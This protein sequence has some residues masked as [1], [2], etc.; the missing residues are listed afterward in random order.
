MLQWK[1]SS[2]AASR[3][4]VLSAF[5]LYAEV[6]ERQRAIQLS[7]FGEGEARLPSPPSGED[8]GSTFP[9]PTAHL[10]QSGLSALSD[11]FRK[12]KEADR[13]D[14][15][16]AFIERAHRGIGHGGKTYRMAEVALRWWSG[17]RQEVVQ[18]LASYV[19]DTPDDSQFQLALVR[20][21]AATGQ[22]S[23]RSDGETDKLLDGLFMA[24][25]KSGQ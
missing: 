15:V 21:C 23:Q 12:A 3:D 25:D 4:D 7:G 1:L 9:F 24:L 5:D 19:R 18:T 10:D 14:L 2:L 8:L 20:A 6:V 11:L 13:A 22:D 17:Q 16:K